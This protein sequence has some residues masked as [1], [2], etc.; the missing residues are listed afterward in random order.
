MDTHGS[1][2]AKKKKSELGETFSLSGKGVLK[3]KPYVIRRSIRQSQ[4]KNPQ[5]PGSPRVTSGWRLEEYSDLLQ[6]DYPAH[7]LF[8]SA[9]YCPV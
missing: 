3:P 9:L 2:K 7:I 1:S 4:M 8:P 5:I 6:Y